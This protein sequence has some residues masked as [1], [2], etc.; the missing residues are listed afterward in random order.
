[1]PILLKNCSFVITQ[2]EKREILRNKDILIDKNRVAEI[3]NGLN[4]SDEVIDCTNK[5]VM[6]GLINLHT[7]ASMSLFRGLAD[8]LEFWKA[9]PEKIW[10][11]EPKLKGEDC[12]IG[13]LLSIIEMIKSGTTCAL[14]MYFFGKDVLKAAEEACMRYNFNLVIFDL[15]T[16]EYKNAEE[17]LKIT[18][19]LLADYKKNDLQMAS[20]G[21]HSIYGCPKEYLLKA[22]E[23]AD[24][25]D[26]LLHMHIAETRKE[27]YDCLNKENKRPVEYLNEIGFLGANVIGAHCV[28][29]TKNEVELLAK[30]NVKV[31][32]CPASNMKLASGGVSPIPEMFN[33]N[34]KIGLGT[35]SVVSNNNL[36]MFEEMKF[37][38]LLHK[39]HRWD[40][41]VIPAQK[42]L[43]MATIN[44][45]EAL[46][47][48]VGSIQAG[49]NADLLLIDKNDVSLVPTFNLI[50]NLVYSS[51]GHVV[52]DVIINGKFVM[53]NREI[54]TL[55]EEETKEKAIKAAERLNE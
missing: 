35:D 22:K 23:L 44:G 42:A 10:K 14:D 38:A 39:A 48:N 25:N 33:A 55:N 54:L 40:S 11:L 15:P 24:K 27:V 3:G 31:A 18:K 30:N 4:K 37:A 19:G 5:V 43:D 41:T 2:N 26:A 21:P 53:K 9:W 20:V 34:V 52:K 16:A 47:L 28:W 49:K 7:H 17:A 36:D 12:Y 45:A 1:M 51:S 29:L 46:K 50:S 6:P 32:H 8:D 13:A